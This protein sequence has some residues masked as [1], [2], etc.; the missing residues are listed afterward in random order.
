LFLGQDLFD[1]PF[2]PETPFYA[3]QEWIAANPG[4]TYMQPTNKCELY[5]IVFQ[6][7]VFMQLFNIINARKLGNKDYNVFESFFNNG[8]FLV[9]FC[10]V[11]SCRS[12]WSSSVVKPSALCP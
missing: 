7:F 5:T 11:S 3:N 8:Y 10:S 9:I 1:L 2:T 6:A 4:F 12:P